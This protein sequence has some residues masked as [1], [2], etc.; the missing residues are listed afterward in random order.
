MA[1]NALDKLD[2][3]LNRFLTLQT[4]VAMNNLITVVDL[5]LPNLK[6]LDLSRNYLKAI[7]DLT[8]LPNLE[9]LLLGF[10]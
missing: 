10:N 8:G 7:P 9:R 4:I 3:V 6:E 5:S 2:S 1:N